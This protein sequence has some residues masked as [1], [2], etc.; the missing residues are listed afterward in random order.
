MQIRH[1]RIKREKVVELERWGFAV[2]R[3]RVVAT[4][5]Q[6]ICIA[7]RCDGS[8]AVQRAA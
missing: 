3:Q 8:K 2:E 7:N 6:P 1:S 5:R 4:Q